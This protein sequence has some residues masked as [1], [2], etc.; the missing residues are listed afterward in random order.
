MVFLIIKFVLIMLKMGGE[1]LFLYPRVT[2]IDTLGKRSAPPYMSVYWCYKMLPEKLIFKEINESN[3]LCLFDHKS[4][5][6]KND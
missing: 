2:Y 5:E 3:Q 1:L 4:M 6:V